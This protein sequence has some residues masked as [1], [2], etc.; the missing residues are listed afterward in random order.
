MSDGEKHDDQRG[1]DGENDHSNYEL[2]YHRQ[3][4]LEVGSNLRIIGDNLNNRYEQ[5]QAV[6]LAHIHL[7]NIDE[8]EIVHHYFVILVHLFHMFWQR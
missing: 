2:L 8:E 5:L 6:E 4:Q 1:S 7:Q 3:R